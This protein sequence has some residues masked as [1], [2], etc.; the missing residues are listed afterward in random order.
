MRRKRPQLDGKTRRKRPQ[1][2]GK[3]RPSR[4][5]NAAFSSA[6]RDEV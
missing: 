6:W 1:L 4:Y 3:M 2:I 5:A